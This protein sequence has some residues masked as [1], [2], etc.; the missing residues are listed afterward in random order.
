MDVLSLLLPMM[1]GAFSG[2][3]TSVL[4]PKY[5][6]GP[7]GNALAG[8]IGGGLGG[9]ILVHML[10]PAQAGV[11]MDPDIGVIFGQIVGGALGGSLLALGVGLL[12]WALQR[13]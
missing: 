12:Q 10:T 9:Y 2:N 13:T 4:V 11:T 3:V 5:N 7:R 6:L 1:S 8:A